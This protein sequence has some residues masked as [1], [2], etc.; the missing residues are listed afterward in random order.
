MGKAFSTI[1]REAYVFPKIEQTVI[2]NVVKEWL[3]TVDLPIYGTPK[4][5]SKLLAALVDEPE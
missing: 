2:K 3:E 1:L 5:I 4:T